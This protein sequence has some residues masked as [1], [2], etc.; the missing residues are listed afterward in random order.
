MF[1]KNILPQT[2]RS[3]ICQTSKLQLFMFV[4]LNLHLF[5]W[6]HLCSS[7]WSANCCQA[8]NHYIPNESVFIMQDSGP[9]VWWVFSFYIFRS[10][11]FFSTSCHELYKS[12]R[13]LLF[14]GRANFHWF[15]TY[16]FISSLSFICL[17]ILFT[18]IHFCYFLQSV[19]LNSRI[20]PWLDPDC[21]H[22]PFQFIIHLSS[23]HMVR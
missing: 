3:K 20:E 22:N 9:Y 4:Q 21:F 11:I 8:E 2:S 15:I 23:N 18:C 10:L 12:L 7:I 6:R 13:S 16:K 1:Q 14:V 5:S 17:F 19:Q